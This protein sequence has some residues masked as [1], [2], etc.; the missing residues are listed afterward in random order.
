MKKQ[1][2]FPFIFLF[3]L[4]FC[5]CSLTEASK[6]VKQKVVGGAKYISQKVKGVNKR[7]NQPNIV[8]VITDDQGYGDLGCTGNPVIKTPHTDQLAKES[9]WLTD[10]HVAPTCSPTRAA[11]MSGHWT[12]RT[13]V[14]HTI[15]GRSMLRANEGTLGQFFKDNGYETGMFGKWHL[16]DN[17]PYRPEDRGFTEVYRHGG[18]GV[19]QT[20]DVWDNAYFDGGYFHNGKI[21]QAKG[22]CTDV[23]FEFGHQFIRKC[24]K[25]KKP[26]LAYISTNAPHGPFHCPQKYLDMY[27]DQSEKIAS[28]FG[29]ITNVD[30]NV[31]KTRALL[32]KLGVYEDT[33]FIFTTDNGTASGRQ[34]FN[35]GMRG[36]KNSEYDGGHRVPFFMHW[37]KG[38]MNKLKK[39]N[40]L[41]HAVDIAPTLLDLCGGKKPKGYEF[42][43]TSIRKVLQAKGKVDWP[44]RMLITDSQRVKDP[45]KWRKSS[46]MSQGWRLV[47]QKELYD[48]NADPGQEKNVAA[49]HSERVAK[50]QAFYDDWWAELEPTFAETTELHIGH[51]EHPVVSLTSHDWIGGPTPWNQGHNRSKYPLRRGRE[52]KHEGHW[53]LKVLKTGKYQIEVMRWPAE[54]GKAINEELVAGANVP[55]ASKAFRAQVGQSIGAKSVTLRLNGKTLQTKPVTK[56]AK[57]VVF[58]TELTKG[59]HELAPFF[60]VPEGELGCYYAVITTL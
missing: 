44:D 35:A 47:N 43:G 29:M 15:M 23:F 25:Q 59:K 5:G 55:G 32:K 53:A 17:Y 51:K 4:P 49:Q 31:G 19:G 8:I 9:V 36:Q 16:G 2:I 48:I 10:Y 45:I 28:F 34:I 6:S 3:A 18:G 57:S 27:K 22:F 1:S 46:V 21:V 26:F 56:G 7:T 52:A 12:N 14:W 20:P 40:T 11:L 60:S 33:I 39:V 42:D 30:D 50:M 58:Q 37:P 13:G 24:V 41:C 54:S 38:G